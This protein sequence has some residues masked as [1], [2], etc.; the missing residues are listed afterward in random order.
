M[1]KK[2][3]KEIKELTLRLCDLESDKYFFNIAAVRGVVSKEEREFSIKKINKEIDETTKE[4]KRLT[5]C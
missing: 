1:D 2:L 3:I 5:T 4:L